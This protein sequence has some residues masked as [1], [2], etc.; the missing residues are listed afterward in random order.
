MQIKCEYCGTMIDDHEDKCPNCGAVNVNVKRVA[1]STPKTIEELSEWYKARNLPSYETTRFFIGINYTEPRAFGIYEENGEFIVYK[2][3]ATGERAIRYRG[4]DEEYAVN[5]L[6]LKLKSEILN[7]K[8]LNLK[9]GNETS[10]S[11]PLSEK[12]VNIIFYSI[13]IP[14]A[15]II[16]FIVFLLLYLNVTNR[17]GLVFTVV[18]AALWFASVITFQLM[19][20]IC[21]SYKKKHRN[22]KIRFLKNPIVWLVSTP[23]NYGAHWISR[24]IIILLLIIPRWSDFDTQYY[25]Y[26]QRIYAEYNHE[27]YEY[28][29]DRN[30]YRYVGYDALPVELQTNSIDYEY[31]WNSDTVSWNMTPFEESVYYE[32]N[33][34]THGSSSDSDYDWDSGSDWDSGGTDWD[35]DW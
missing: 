33:C 10:Y 29:Y 28:E 23:E 1:D 12:R 3:K 25:N 31:D 32:V 20:E 17:L 19:T 2:N 11:D 34:E 21:S 22:K 27:W 35:S 14:L 26:N 15:Y 9:E 24:F 13:F 16:P 4:T 7:Q 6:F 30:D 18:G 5:E 8:A